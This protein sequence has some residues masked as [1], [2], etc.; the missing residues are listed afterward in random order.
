LK[1]L[2]LRVQL[3]H[4]VG[5]RCAGATPLHASV[6]VLHTNGIHEV[7]VDACD[8]ER[9]L[10][11]GS[12]EEQ[13]QRAGWFP[14]TDDRPRTCATFEVLDTFLTLTYQAKTT[15]Y[16]YYSVLEKLTNNTGIKPPNRYQAF[17]R[18]VREYTH[19]LM[20]K[21]AGR[22][23]AQSGVMGTRQGELAV[24]C[25]CCPV[26]GVNLPEGWENAPPGSQ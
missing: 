10:W 2:G 20:L 17:L 12:P 9:R 5:D 4:R 8:C 11:A 26:P 1:T 19:L 24:R 14:A 23:H 15:M 21:R 7:A 22:G 6:V 25:P 13:L 16:D 18:M 3:G